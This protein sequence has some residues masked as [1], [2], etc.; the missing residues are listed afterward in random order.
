MHTGAAGYLGQ[1]V[2][3]ALL[4]AG[5]DVVGLVRNDVGQNGLGCRDE[6]NTDDLDDPAALADATRDV[7]AVI[8]TASARQR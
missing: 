7:D 2:G 3:R 8:E 4:L 5:H 6:I 1:A